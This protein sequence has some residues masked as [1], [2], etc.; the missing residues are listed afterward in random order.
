MHRIVEPLTNWALREWVLCI[1]LIDCFKPA[2]SCAAFALRCPHQ[3]YLWVAVDV[4]CLAQR[5]LGVAVD[6]G[7]RSLSFQ[8]PGQPAKLGTQ[9]LA[10][11]TPLPSPA[12]PNPSV[13]RTTSH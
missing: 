3:P 6:R 12:Q 4:E 1:G 10:V 5:R 7:E 8:R 2:T 9:L 13:I 11:T